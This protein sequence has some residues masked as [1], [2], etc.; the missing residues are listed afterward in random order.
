MSMTADAMPGLAPGEES[1]NMAVMPPPK[2]AE[3]GAAL[4]V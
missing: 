1:G 4:V 3:T 2:P